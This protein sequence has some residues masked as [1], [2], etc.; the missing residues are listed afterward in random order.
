M[1]PEERNSVVKALAIAC[2][3]TGTSLSDPA[4]SFILSE[5]ESRSASDVLVGLRRCAR[6]CKGRLSL[7]EILKAIDHVDR[8]LISDERAARSAYLTQLR[9]CALVECIPWNEA[10]PDSVRRQLEE[11]GYRFRETPRKPVKALPH[12]TEQG[13]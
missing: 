11:K 6:E 10:D 1:T 12:W 7:A 3:V 13:E 9:G 5:L 4:K 8:K 2:E